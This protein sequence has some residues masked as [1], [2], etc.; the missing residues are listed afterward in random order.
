MQKPF[1]LIRQLSTVLLLSV[2]SVVNAQNITETFVNVPNLFTSGWAQQNLSAPAGASVWSQGDSA[3]AFPSFDFAVPAASDYAVCNFNSTTGTGTISNW[4]FT[5]TI[6]TLSNGDTIYF[7]TR[8]STPGTTIYPDRLQVR[9]STNGSSVN[10]GTTATSVGDFTSLQLDINPNLTTI[11]YPSVWTLQTVIISG[12]PSGNLTGRIAFRYFVTNGGPSGTNSDIVGIDQ[13]RYRDQ[14][15]QGGPSITVGSVTGS[16]F[17]PGEQISV[18]YTIS[19]TFNAGNTF[20]AQLSN[21]I[22]EFTTPVT[23]GSVTSTSG[24]T[25]SATIP[26]GITPSG[27]YRIRVVSSNPVVNSSANSVDLVGNPASVTATPSSSTVCPG[28]SSTITASLPD[29]LYAVA[30]AGFNGLMRFNAAS[31]GT[32]VFMDTFP[33]TIAPYAGDFGPNGFYY[34]LDD[35]T[36]TLYRVDVGSFTWTTVGIATGLNVNHVSTGLAWNAAN[37]TMYATTTDGT[38]TSLYSINVNTAA[39]T[40]IANISNVPTGI[41]LAINNTGQ[42]YTADITTDRLYSVNLTTG[43]GTLIGNLGVNIAFAQDA[44]FDPITGVLYMAAYD[45]TNSQ[46]QLRTVNTTTGATTL[47]GALFNNLEM[48]AFAIAGAPTYAWSNGG[49]TQSI[50]VTQAGTYTVTMTNQAGC[51]ATASVPISSGTVNASVSPSNPTLCTGSVTLTASGGGTY[52]WSNGSTASSIS[53]SSGGTYTVTVTGTNGCTATASSTVTTGNVNASIS[54]ANPTVCPGVQVTLTASGGSGYSWNTGATTNSISVSNTGTYTVTVTSGNCTGTASVNVGQGSAP[55][56]QINAGGP[57]A[58]CQGGSVQLTALNGSSYNWSNGQTTAAITAT[59]A[60]L[61]VV[62]VT[63]SNGCTATASQNVTVNSAPTA[64]IQAN[65][66]TTIC[67]GSSVTL[68][69]TGGGTY[70]WST[71]STNSSITVNSAGTFTVT[72]TNANSCTATASQQVSVQSSQASITANGSTNI[73]QGQSVTLTASQGQ[74]YQW[75]NGQTS[76]SITV[77]SA[78]A[79]LVTVTAQGGCTAT[80]SQGV[81]VNNSPTASINVNGPTALCGG[82]TTSLTA[83]GGGTYNWSNGSTSANIIVN[84]PG[85]YTVTVT[86]NGGCTATASQV[87]NSSN[88][89]TALITPSGSTNFCS[90]GSVTLTAS[91]GNT[92]SWNNGS[93][94]A[95]ITVSAS[96]IFTVTV[97]D[98]NGCSATA[99]QTVVVTVPTASITPGGPTTFCPGGSVTLTANTANSYLWSNGATSQSITASASG[100]YTVTVVDANNCT[101]TASQQV[102]VNNNPSTTITPQSSTICANGGSTTLTAGTGISFS[103]SNGGTTQTISVNAPGTYTVTVTISAGCTASASQSITQLPAIAI[104][105]NTTP[106]SGTNGTIDITVTNAFNPT[107][108]QWSNGASSQD[109]AN[110]A[111][112]A[113]TVTVTDA[114]GCS[115]TQQFT[116]ASTVGISDVAL[117]EMFSIYPNPAQ[118]V[119]TVSLETANVLSGKIWVTDAQGRMVFSTAVTTAGTYSTTLNTA[120]WAAGVYQVSFTADGYTAAKKLVVMK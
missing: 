17:C 49:N 56:A 70:S 10:A 3:A 85:T 63:G 87:I 24:G 27:L 48:D 110:L 105:G 83:G 53:V 84:A 30:L 95:A 81:T 64:G 46:G 15:S 40:F 41:W 1:T 106:S 98:A 80:A 44:D 2:A 61:Y 114:N 102:T 5:P 9:I 20:T 59:T 101:A 71:G 29:R 68:T 8:T 117:L 62:T 21:A 47:V 34:I 100:T 86:G 96:G 111:P 7:Y 22:G 78:G 65:G 75:S 99:Q 116:V 103:W 67:P 50:T 115:A 69:A 89:P 55:N 26:A 120:D 39:A 33:T 94:N 118:N 32:A 36:Y 57:T 18:P 12:L 13:F 77:N 113:Y 42:A 109:V 76:Q 11:G 4:L 45:S 31:P 93:T 88:G 119:A 60:G 38:V 66:S 92:Y 82:Q 97:T 90:G 54:P 43:A 73:C 72:V 58:F 79:Y 6:N 37:S 28:S 51:T 91:G 14:V 52:L 16:P 19:G 74:S 107:T 35:N 23:I 104:S 25:I 112:G 108:Y